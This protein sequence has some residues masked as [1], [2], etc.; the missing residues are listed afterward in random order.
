M[1]CKNC[2]E[3]IEDGKLECTKCGTKVEDKKEEI[4]KA[5]IVN[6]SSSQVNNNSVPSAEDEKNANLLCVI[7]L[8]LYFG[9]S[10][11]SGLLYSISSISGSYVANIGGLCPL[12]GIVLMIIARVKYP[13]NKFAKVLMWV[14]IIFTLLAIVGAIIVVAACFYACSTM[15]TSGCG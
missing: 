9:S 6:N 4:I 5:E 1:Y 15:D 11:I 10:A 7:S 14:Y 8:I 2:G 3:K 12:A 13:K